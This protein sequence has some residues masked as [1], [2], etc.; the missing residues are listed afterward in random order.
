M[1]VK[2]NTQYGQAKTLG[3]AELSEAKM[4]VKTNTQ[5][6]QAKTRGVA[7]LSEAKMKVKTNTQ[8]RQ[9]K[10][11]GVAELSKTNR[12]HI[13]HNSSRSQMQTKVLD[14]LRQSLHSCT[15]HCSAD[16]S[17]QFSLHYVS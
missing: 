14:L 5:C 9:T 11:R 13:E 15:S 10:T 2:T 7:E 4:K 12:E 8:C 16:A 1:K 3:L 17:G 6:G